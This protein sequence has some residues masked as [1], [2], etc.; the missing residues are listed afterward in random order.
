MGAKGIGP[1]GLTELPITAKIKAARKKILFPRNEEV[2]LKSDGTG[3]PI[4]SQYTNDK[5]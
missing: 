1:R 2:T 4:L 3:G 5:K